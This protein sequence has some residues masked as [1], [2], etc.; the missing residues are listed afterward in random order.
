[1]S[2]KA[3]W[4]T[5]GVVAA[6]VVLTILILSLSFEVPRNCDAYFDYD[7][8]S[9]VSLTERAEWNDAEQRYEMRKTVLAYEDVTLFRE[10]LRGLTWRPMV[11]KPADTGRVITVSFADGY[12]TISDN[13]IVRYNTAGEEVRRGVVR[14]GGT[15]E[16]LFLYFTADPIAA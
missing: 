2:S 9:S 14:F 11:G 15:Y 1:M 4:I 3:K 8:V 6:V 5:V 13:L 10:S 12:T 16:D 7:T